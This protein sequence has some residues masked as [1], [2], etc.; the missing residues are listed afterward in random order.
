MPTWG[1]ILIVVAVVAVIS[2][3]VWAAMRARRTR[4]LRSTFGPEYDR[5]VQ[6]RESRKDAE[7]ELQ[8]RRRR[9]EQLTIRPL[10]PEQRERYRTQWQ[11]VQSR[12]VDQPGAAVRE[13]DLL[14]TQAM[15]DRG[16]PMEEFEQQAA[17]VS[18]DHPNVVQNY[19][20]AHA[21]F[22]RME[23]GDESTE[24]LRQAMVHYRAL[25]SELLEA[26]DQ[27]DQGVAHQ[28]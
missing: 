4:Q 7:S 12:F 5:T 10:G 22:I 16:Y 19:R 26:P 14:V 6:T 15:R 9:R 25:F 24:A 17:D 2:L 20:S 27:R 18:V 13:A 1:W 11:A 21:I 28:A 8:A 3:A 23:D